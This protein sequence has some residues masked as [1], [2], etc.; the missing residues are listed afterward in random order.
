M[1]I[2][3][4]IA[5]SLLLALLT[6]CGQKGPLFLPPAAALRATPQATMVAPNYSETKADESE[7][8]AVCHF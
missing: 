8:E 2:S 6:A 1:S 5:S 3:A 4:R 7:D